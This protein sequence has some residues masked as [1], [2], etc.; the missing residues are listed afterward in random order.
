M[1]IYMSLLSSMNIKIK[2]MFKSI[3]QQTKN[4]KAKENKKQSNKLK[5]K[6][7]MKEIHYKKKKR[8]LKRIR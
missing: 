3:N 4:Y 8:R 1:L 7:I 2:I 6:K 5:Q